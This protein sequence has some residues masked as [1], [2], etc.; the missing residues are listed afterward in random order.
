[1]KR[2]HLLVGL[3]AVGLAGCVGGP[4]RSANPLG[5]NDPNRDLATKEQFPLQ[6]SADRDEV[7]RRFEAAHPG[8]VNW[9]YVWG[10]D[11]WFDL[12]DVASWDLSFGRGFGVNAH[13]TEFGQL[14]VNWWDGMSWGQRGR[15]WG[16]WETSEVDRGVGP[17]YW[18]EVERT[19]KWGTKTLWEHEYKY[20]GWDIQEPGQ[21]TGDKRI[22]G[23]WS[24]L[25]ATAHLFAVGASLSASPVEAVDFLAG[26]FP[27]GL[28]ANVAG[29]HHPIFD[30]MGDDTWSEMAKGLRSEMGE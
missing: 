26:A 24:E 15:A 28:V 19:P 8:V 9:M 16:V 10:R 5:N 6:S 7:N 18:V 22:H 4:A 27:V 23:D 29:Y 12:M 21:A 11:R 20:S 25:G 14:G 13:L 1:M 2:V 30:I 17:F 3:A